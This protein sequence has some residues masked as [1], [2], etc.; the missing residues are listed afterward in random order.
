M[1]VMGGGRS[2]GAQHSDS[3]HPLLMNLGGIKVVVPATAA[4]A[5]GLL[6]SAIRGDGPVVFLQ[7]ASRGGEMGEVPDG[8]VLVPL[9]SA[10]VVRA[11]RAT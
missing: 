6:K 4:D 3:P 10:N 11:G 7:P 8:D 5:K 2:S 1:A 9:G